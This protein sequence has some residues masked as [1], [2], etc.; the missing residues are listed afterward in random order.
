MAQ[1]ML[2]PGTYVVAVSGGVDS[3]VLL[4]LL[5]EQEHAKLI[6]AHFDHGIR[7]DSA[8]DRVLV[9]QLATGYGLPFVYNNGHLGAQASEAQAR[10]ARYAFLRSVQ[11][12][13]GARSIIMA[14]HED[15]L[16]ETA[17]LN[18][19]RGTGRKGL[20]SLK[21]TDELYRPLLN[22]KKETLI[23]YARANGLVWHEDST[24]M[25]TTY[26]RNYVRR[27]IMPR[28]DGESREQLRALVSQAQKTNEKIDALLAEQLHAQPASDVLNRHWF[29]M[30]PHEV[31][32]EIM[33]AWLRANG[34]AG[35]DRR[36]IERIVTRAK[37]L[38]VH[39]QIDVDVNHMI[40]VKSDN[41]ALIRRDR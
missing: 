4:H 27:K 28:F 12:G 2:A 24:N 23:A 3:V 7:D 19:L 8:R 41:L 35:F 25:D 16:L 6:V 5:L 31:A 37:V 13:S 38:A 34:I 10:E 32:R 9:Q 22:T 39:K 17:I 29:I 14:H 40:V 26:L 36:M 18:M 1:I 15:D 11:Q 33:A 20:S 21:N 30:L